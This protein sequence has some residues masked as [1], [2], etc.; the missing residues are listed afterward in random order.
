MMPGQHVHRWCV[1]KVSW[2]GV[3]FVREDAL[4]HS[5]LVAWS[6]AVRRVEVEPQP[7]VR[8]EA[9]VE[10]LCSLSISPAFWCL[11]R[12]LLAVVGAVVGVGDFD[13]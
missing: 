12:V 3:V 2:C 6:R 7:R 5:L 4:V 8:L 13:F 9:L 1:S 11:L 10:Y